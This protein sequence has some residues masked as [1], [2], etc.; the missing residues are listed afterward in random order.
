MDEQD[1]NGN[2]IVI[3]RMEWLKGAAFAAGTFWVNYWY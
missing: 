2:E 1:T 3:T